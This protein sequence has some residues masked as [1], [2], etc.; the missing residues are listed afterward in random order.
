MIEVQ[1]VG[2]HKVVAGLHTIFYRPPSNLFARGW[3]GY[4]MNSKYYHNQLL[5]YMTGIK[6]LSLSRSSLSRT[7]VFYPSRLEQ[8]RIVSVFESINSHISILRIHAAKLQK[9]KDGM[10]TYFFG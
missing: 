3:L 2:Q 4:W 8:E 10:M 9:L 7:E 1:D 5:P 6:V